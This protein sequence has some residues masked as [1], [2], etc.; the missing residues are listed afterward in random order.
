MCVNNDKCKVAAISAIATDIKYI[1]AVHFKNLM[2]QVENQLETKFDK[3]MVNKL[4]VEAGSL[5]DKVTNLAM[6][7]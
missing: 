1:R 3:V 2:E 7:M 6:D 4:A 5:E